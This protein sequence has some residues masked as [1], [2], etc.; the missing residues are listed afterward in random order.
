MTGAAQCNT[1]A[2]LRFLHVEGCPWG[3]ASGAAA[4]RG[5]FE[6][7]RWMWERGC[8]W[9]CDGILADTASSGNVE[10]TAW[11]KQQPGVTCRRRAMA[12]AAAQ[13]HTAVCEFLHAEG[14]PWDSSACSS[15]AR[16]NHVDTLRWLRE[17][18]C[19][20]NSDQSLIHAA[21]AGSV[22]VLAY[23]LEQGVVIDAASLTH[24]LSAAGAFNQLAAA[25]WLRQQGAVWPSVLRYSGRGAWTGGSLAW[26]RAEGC[27]SPV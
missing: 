7:L 12:A 11:V 17:H 3:A 16:N 18:D 25:Q 23:M 9:C 20:W 4:R 21:E 2:V 22:Q 1:L 10:M 5:D 15:A 14:C 8:P 19:F 6:A 13:G 26:A 24:L 27:T